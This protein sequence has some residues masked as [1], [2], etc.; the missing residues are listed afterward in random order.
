VTAP[1]A[2]PVALPPWHGT[3]RPPPATAESEA[4]SWSAGYVCPSC[5]AVASVRGGRVRVAHVQ[6]CKRSWLSVPV[7]TA[8]AAAR[9]ERPTH[10]C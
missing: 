4:R 7:S 5:R 9:T 10:G 2:P 6:G 8:R 3:G 1:A